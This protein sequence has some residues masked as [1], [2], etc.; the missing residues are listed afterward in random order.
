MF[1]R[2]ILEGNN[3]GMRPTENF[4]SGSSKCPPTLTLS[5][6][7]HSTLLS[8]SVATTPPTGLR[9]MTAGV[10]SLKSS[11]SRRSSFLA[12]LH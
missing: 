2:G 7:R 1:A 9:S 6:D 3:I 11:L 12:V 10:W 8:F 5:V 4:I